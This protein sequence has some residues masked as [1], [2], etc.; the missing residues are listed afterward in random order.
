[1][2]NVILQSA[3]EFPRSSIYM[4]AKA[5][6]AHRH[7]TTVE[8]GEDDAWDSAS[9]SDSPRHS[10]L[11]NRWGYTSINTPPRS[12]PDKNGWTIVRKSHREKQNHDL[13]PPKT[14]H[15]ADVDGDIVL[16][17]SDTESATADHGPPSASTDVKPKQDD[18]SLREDVDDIVKG[19]RFL[20]PSTMTPHLPQ[21]R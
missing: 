12:Y 17:E 15:D 16:G 7:P 4:S 10:T 5:T 19:S 18:T 11:A 6:S 9:D 14:A 3:A 8:W 1:M 20:F 21:I 2:M 13:D